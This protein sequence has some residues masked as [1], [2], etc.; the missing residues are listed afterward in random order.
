MTWTDEIASSSVFA[1]I[2]QDSLKS[3][4]S[5]CECIYGSP[6]PAEVVKDGSKILM[7]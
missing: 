2:L 5:S 7:R 4:I 6:S 3:F 1:V